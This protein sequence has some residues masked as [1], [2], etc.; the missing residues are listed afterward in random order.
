MQKKFLRTFGI[1]FKTSTVLILMFGTI[2]ISGEVK[3]MKKNQPQPELNAPKGPVLRAP[4]PAELQREEIRSGVNAVGA[5]MDYINNHAEAGLLAIPGA[6]NAAEQA[7][8][9]K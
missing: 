3:A 5:Y 4:T 9:K 2:V 8:K 6:Y 7:K 1:S